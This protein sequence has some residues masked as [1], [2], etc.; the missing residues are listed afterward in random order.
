[1]SA[2]TEQ[3]LE[4]VFEFPA[5]QPSQREIVDRLIMVISSLVALMIDQVAGGVDAV[6]IHSN[7]SH[8]NNVAD[9]HQVQDGS[10]KLLYLS[11]ERLMTE[12]ML[13][14]LRA[15]YRRTNGF[16][17]SV[18]VEIHT[19]FCCR[20]SLIISCPLSRHDYDSEISAPLQRSG[21]RFPLCLPSG[22]AISQWEWLSDIAFFGMLNSC[23]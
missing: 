21:H 15:L 11:P 4:S 1:M 17:T 18:A 22:N 19:H 12:H 20:Y 8:E 9:W 13:V 7:R 16:G 3:I 5:F 23:G 2:A 14:T 10:I 6:C